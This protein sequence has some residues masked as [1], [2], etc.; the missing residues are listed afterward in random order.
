MLQDK[1][2]S[3]EWDPGRDDEEPDDDVLDP[4]YVLYQLFIIFI[5]SPPPPIIYA[6][7]LFPELMCSKGPSLWN[8]FALGN[9]H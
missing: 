3:A 2:L 7:Y 4:A 8:D 1:N 5:S 9:K 6:M